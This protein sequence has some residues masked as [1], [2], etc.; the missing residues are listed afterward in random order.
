MFGAGKG[1]A[2]EGKIA[3]DLLQAT[4][5]AALECLAASAEAVPGRS[6]S[7]VSLGV[8]GCSIQG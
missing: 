3:A 4:P 2:R 6:N 5:D 1:A 7:R 8:A